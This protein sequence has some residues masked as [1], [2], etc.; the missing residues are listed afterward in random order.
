MSCDE[1]WFSYNDTG[2]D[3]PPQDFQVSVLGSREAIFSWLPPAV[4]EHNGIIIYYT[5]VL[6]DEQFNVSGAVISVS[7]TEHTFTDLEE[8]T[9]YSCSVAAATSGGLGPFTELVNFTTLEASESHIT[10]N[11]KLMTNHTVLHT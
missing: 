5:L 8:Y 10:D 2:P 4:S 3:T 6:K 9:R 1:D 7:S 11:S